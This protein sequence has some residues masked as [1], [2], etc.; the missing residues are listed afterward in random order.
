M[1][2][3]V[4]T[5]IVPVLLVA[6]FVPSTT[7]NAISKSP[8]A[9][10][11]PIYAQFQQFL[12]RTQYL[13]LVEVDAPKPSASLTIT[14]KLKLELVDKAGA[15]DPEMT[16]AG[17]T[18]GAA[19]DPGCTNHDVLEQT[20]HVS[21]EELKTRDYRVLGRFF[22]HHPDAADSYPVG[23][24]HCNHMLQGPHGHQG[25]ITVVVSYGSWDC[26]ATFKGTHSSVPARSGKPNPNVENE[27]ASEPKCL[28][29]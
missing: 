5:V 11:H 17:M 16:A 6:A 9:I 27:T 7:A 23:W 13:V 18:S 19:V 26:S 15:P 20:E 25:L 8:I 14:W 12:Y 3:W 22:W 10:E 24:Y 2:R 21:S 29:I 4:R 1:K 28:Y